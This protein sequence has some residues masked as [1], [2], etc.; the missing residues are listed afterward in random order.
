MTKY[1][2]R[3]TPEAWVRDNAIE[4]DPQ[5]PQEWDCTGF[6]A[7]HEDYLARLAARFGDTVADG[8]VDAED[9]FKGDPA[10][11]EWVRD[12]RGPFTITVQAVA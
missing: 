12:W 4:V 6:A 11:P 2:A 5:G 3:F 7:G 1:T 9:R 8:V 10:A